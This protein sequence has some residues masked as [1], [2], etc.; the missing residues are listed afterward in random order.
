MANKKKS[1]KMSASTKHEL[2]SRRKTARKPLPKVE[3]S[4]SDND[5]ALGAV[6]G[7]SSVVVFDL[8]GCLSD[9]SWR[10]Q[11]VQEHPDPDARFHHYHSALHND[12]A[13]DK[14]TDLLSAC[15]GSGMFPV[16][17]TARPDAYRN[18][19]AQW[20]SVVCCLTENKDCAILMRDNGDSRSTVDIKRDLF[21]LLAAE[22][23][24]GSIIAAYDD[25]EDVVTMYHETFGVNAFI[26]DGNGVYD[27]LGLQQRHMRTIAQETPKAKSVGESLSERMDAAVKGTSEALRTGAPLGAVNWGG[28]GNLHVQGEVSMTGQ[29]GSSP[30]YDTVGNAL[31]AMAAT[32]ESKNAQY[33]SNGLKVG[34]VMKALFPNGLTANSAADHR[35]HHLFNL[36]IVKLTRFVNSGMKHVDSIHDAAVYCAMVEAEAAYHNLQFKR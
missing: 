24:L 15:I 14:G 6:A 10:H 35:M 17:I 26:L 33:G 32:F 20:L 18:P 23:G 3:S 16:F 4:L 1:P 5:I 21:D 19:T 13:L 34:D 25:R 12:R 2:A 11:F 9:D 30:D 36:V 27:V 31:R 29:V 8:D 22:V 7:K 28:E